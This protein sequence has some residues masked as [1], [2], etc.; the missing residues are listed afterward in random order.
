MLLAAAIGLCVG[1][2]GD[3][4][5]VPGQVSDGNWGEYPGAN[6][7]LS[8][9]HICTERKR[10]S[11]LRREA[12][13]MAR[14]ARAR[15][16]KSRSRIERYEALRDREVPP[17]DDT[18]ELRSVSTRLGRKTVEIHGLTK[19]FDGPPLI[20]DWEF[21]LMRDARVGIIGD[22]G[23]GKST[24]LKLIA[25]QLSPDSGEIIRGETV[26][27]G[28]FS[29]ECEEMDLSLSLIH[30][31]Q[32]R[33][34]WVF[35]DPAGMLEG[36][37]QGVAVPYHRIAVELPLRPQIQAEYR[38]MCIRDSPWTSRCSPSIPDK[39]RPVCVFPPG[40]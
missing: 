39:Y 5:P 8:L 6:D 3:D 1:C 22:N 29:Q 12:E 37:L 7:T 16:T 30:V 9:I 2:A 27:I 21:L 24:L 25:G 20:R 36:E 13:W 23:A 31:F 32:R 10:Q 15:G 33:V 11:L 28:C 18:L 26:K 38:K 34:G 14:G 35:A 17:E 19:G 40:R 4:P